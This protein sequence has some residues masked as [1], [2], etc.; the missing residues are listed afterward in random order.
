MIN[1]NRPVE[2]IPNYIF[3]WFFV[4]FV[5]DPLLFGV[6]LLTTIGSG[7]ILKVAGILGILA[8][9]ILAAIAIY[10]YMLS[11]KLSSMIGAVV[12]GDGSVS[13]EEITAVAG[14]YPFKMGLLIF[15]GNSGGPVLVGVLG[16]MADVF[17]SF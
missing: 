15:L 3:K 16:M 5:L 13:G 14:T 17:V 10:L 6:M 9:P 8:P 11:R 1:K 12:K 7:Q 4:L 2:S